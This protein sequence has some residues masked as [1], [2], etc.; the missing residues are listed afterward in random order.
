MRKEATKKKP[1]PFD[2]EKPSPRGARAADPHPSPCVFRLL[3]ILSTLSRFLLPSYNQKNNSAPGTPING[4][5]ALAV[6]EAMQFTQSSSS[7]SAPSSS[8]ALN[9]AR[10]SFAQGE[11][12]VFH[13]VLDGTSTGGTG[14]AFVAA[15]PASSGTAGPN[16]FL[17]EARGRTAL[18]LA[19]SGVLDAS[20]AQPYSLDG[21]LKPLLAAAAAALSKTRGGAALRL[22][23]DLEQ[24]RQIMS[25]NID[26]ALDRGERIELLVAKTDTLS[27]DAGI[28]ARRAGVLARSERWRAVQGKVAVGLAVAVVVYLLAASLCGVRMECVWRKGKG[29]GP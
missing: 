12:A 9:D 26:A 27:G 2:P 16:A 25:R 8:L 29:G 10:E 18:V 4:A 24:V 7:S 14:L 23:E 13:V 21:A 20:A 17:D 19:E 28:F 15:A 11:D 22:N 3:L 6:L 1:R 5:Q